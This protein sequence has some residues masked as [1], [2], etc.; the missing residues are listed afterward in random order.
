M[1]KIGIKHREMTVAE[2][3]Q[4]RASVAL[5]NIVAIGILMAVLSEEDEEDP[6]IQVTGSMRGIPPNK[7]FQLQEMGVKPYHININ[8]AA[9]DYRLTPGALLLAMIGNFMD[10]RKYGKKDEDAWGP[11]EAVMSAGHGVIIDQQFLSGLAGLLNSG[12][13]GAGKS[14]VTRLFEGA[15]RMTGGFIPSITKEIDSWV[16]PTIPQADGFLETFQRQV[17]VWRWSLD[18][19]IRNALGEPIERPRLPW[20]RVVS[21]DKDLDPVWEVLREKSRKG[22]FIPTVSKAAKINGKPMTDAQFDKYQT[23]TGRLY[24]QKLLADLPRL[25][26]MTPAQTKEYFDKEFGRLR[27]QAR[28]QIR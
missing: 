24:R 11:L 23:I 12:G 2:W 26:R 18:P 4:L 27:E 1:E 15:G 8:G 19:P 13:Q 20:G 5:S 28:N 3:Q 6:W 9:F 16:N 17:P 10:A 7:K 25:R 14:M 21:F 22:V